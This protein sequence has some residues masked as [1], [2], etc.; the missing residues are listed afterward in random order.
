MEVVECGSSTALGISERHRFRLDTWLG[1]N[2]DWQGRFG[3]HMRKA[4]MA[5]ADPHCPDSDVDYDYPFLYSLLWKSYLSRLLTK[6]IN[7]ND[8]NNSTNLLI[9]YF[10]VIRR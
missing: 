4:Y 5:Q 9:L 6:E 1:C 2:L 3:L 10:K 8:N 7:N